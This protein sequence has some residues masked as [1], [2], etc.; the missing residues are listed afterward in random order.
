MM[1]EHNVTLPKD[2]TRRRLLACNLLDFRIQDVKHLSLEYLEREC[3]R[4]GYYDKG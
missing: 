2:E 1:S 3:V 4:R